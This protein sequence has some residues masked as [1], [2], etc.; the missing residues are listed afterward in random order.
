MA[1]EWKIAI[2]DGADLVSNGGAAQQPG[3]DQLAPGT[4]P[5]TFTASRPTGRVVRRR[6]TVAAPRSRSRT[7]E[8]VPVSRAQFCVGV[9]FFST[10]RR[11][12]SGDHRPAR[13]GRGCLPRAQRPRH[14]VTLRE[15]TSSSRSRCLESA[16]DCHRT[17]RTSR[18][19][20]Y[21]Y[22]SRTGQNRSRPSRS[23]APSA[24]SAPWAA[25]SSRCCWVRHTLRRLRCRRRERAEQCDCGRDSVMTPT[26]QTWTLNGKPGT[27]GSVGPLHVRRIS[28]SQA[29]NDS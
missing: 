23:G 16:R 18:S 20:T 2:P 29:R 24:C 9:A 21:D 8:F 10:W 3:S 4:Q 5:W 28:R 25:A 17:C 14:A 15:T 12:T 1:V 26:S 13:I 19:N 11:T 6:S 7:F 22:G 27:D